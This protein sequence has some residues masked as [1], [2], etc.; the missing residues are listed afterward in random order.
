[1]TNNSK[2][3]KI[4]RRTVVAQ[5]QDKP[6]VLSRIAGLFRR[7]G[8]NIASLSVGHSELPGLSRVRG[9]VGQPSTTTFHDGLSIAA[10]APA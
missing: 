4:A 3:Q 9:V 2:S 8:F 5:V 6:G 10:P 7:R 1:M